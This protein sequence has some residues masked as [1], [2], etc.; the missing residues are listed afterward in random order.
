VNLAKKA[1]PPADGLHILVAE[2]HRDSRDALRALLEASGYQV[3]LAED[4]AE[5]VEQALALHPDLILMDIMMPRL[6]GLSATR[7]LR[8]EPSMENT[9]ILALTAMAGA[10]EPALE[11][12]CDDYLRKPIDVPYFFQT[13]HRWIRDGR[14]GEGEKMEN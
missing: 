3:H 6:D 2:D 8:A 11:A 5:A 1:P 4:G 9:P 12:G 14:K 10:R 13:V 7:L